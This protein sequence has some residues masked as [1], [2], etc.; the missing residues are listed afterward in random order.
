MKQKDGSWKSK[1]DGQTSGISDQ[2]DKGENLNQW[3]QKRKRGDN[4]KHHGN[5]GNHQRLPWEPIF[6]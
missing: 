4:N 1:Q 3:D 2:N 5:P 6:Q